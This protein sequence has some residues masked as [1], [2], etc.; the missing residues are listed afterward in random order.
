MK[1]TDKLFRAIMRNLHAYVLLI[2]RDFTV[3]Y[4][5]YYDITGAVKPAETAQV[6]QISTVKNASV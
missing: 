3:F 1:M 5:N 4:T 6:V 2:N